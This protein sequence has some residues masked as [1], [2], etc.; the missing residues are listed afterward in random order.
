MKVTIP[1]SDNHHFCIICYNILGETEYNIVYLIGFSQTANEIDYF[2][3]C[4]FSIGF[5]FLDNFFV[6]NYNFLKLF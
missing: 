2:F 4:L 1:S 3:M 5:P 6:F